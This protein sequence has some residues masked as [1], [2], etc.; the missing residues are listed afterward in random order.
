MQQSATQ[1]Q[2]DPLLIL[3]HYLRVSRFGGNR[4]RGSK[5]PHAP[6]IPFDPDTQPLPLPCCDDLHVPANP[7]VHP[8]YL[9]V[10]AYTFPNFEALSS[11][12]LESSIHLL[13]WQHPNIDCPLLPKSCVD[14]CA[15]PR[16]TLAER[17][18]PSFSD[19]PDQ[20]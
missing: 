7:S 4:F 14:P 1:T 15:T 17:I 9:P 10:S 2:T 18:T 19:H 3:C 5:Q 20:P 6:S 8:S 11:T 13:F 12:P 16:I